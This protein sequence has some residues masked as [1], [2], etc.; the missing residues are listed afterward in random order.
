M[1]KLVLP[2]CEE[3]RGTVLHFRWCGRQH[4]KVQAGS[5]DDG[6]P[7]HHDHSQRGFTP[8]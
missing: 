5:L 6:V 7:N 3:C 1:T 8:R 2:P 4:E